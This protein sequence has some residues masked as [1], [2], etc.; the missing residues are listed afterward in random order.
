MNPGALFLVLLS[1]VEELEKQKRTYPSE[2]F[3]DKNICYK[4]YPASYGL[5]FFFS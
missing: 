1:E 5:P 3:I 4:K 2:I